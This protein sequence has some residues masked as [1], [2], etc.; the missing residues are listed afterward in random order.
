LAQRGQEAL[1]PWVVAQDALLFH[2][3]DSGF[4]NVKNI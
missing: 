3:L 1:Q 2:S 4:S